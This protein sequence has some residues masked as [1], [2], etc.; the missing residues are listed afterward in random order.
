MHHDTNNQK[1][2]PYSIMI[3]QVYMG[4]LTDGFK[5]NNYGTKMFE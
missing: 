4:L 3:N 5:T 1:W 2:L